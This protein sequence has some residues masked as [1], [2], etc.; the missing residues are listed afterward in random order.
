MTQDTRSTFEE[1]LDILLIKYGEDRDTQSF[2]FWQEQKITKDTLARNTYDLEQV[3]K[4]AIRDLIKSDREEIAKAYGG[5]TNCYGKGYSTVKSQING[6]GTDGDIGGFEG[7][8][9]IDT[10]VQMKYCDCDRGAQLEKLLDG[11]DN[12]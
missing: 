6:Y 5:C 11:R 3:L 10:P 8:I 1:K 7:R 9:H 4:Q 2:L 12:T